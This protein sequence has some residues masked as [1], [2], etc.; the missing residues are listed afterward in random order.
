MLW[1]EP[2]QKAQTWSSWIGDIM[3]KTS[4]KD[5]KAPMSKPADEWETPS[6]EEK[7]AFLAFLGECFG[8]DLDIPADRAEELADL[9]V[10]CFM[11]VVAQMTSKRPVG[12]NE[13]KKVL[14]LGRLVIGQ[15]DKTEHDLESDPDNALVDLTDSPLPEKQ[16]FLRTMRSISSSGFFEKAEDDEAE[17]DHVIKIFAGLAAAGGRK[18]RSLDELATVITAAHELG[19][20]L[21]EAHQSAFDQLLQLPSMDGALSGKEG[22]AIVQQMTEGFAEVLRKQMEELDLDRMAGREDCKD[23]KSL[24]TMLG[25]VMNQMMKSAMGDMQKT[26]ES[27]IHAGLDAKLEGIQSQLGELCQSQERL[28]EIQDQLAQL[29]AASRRQEEFGDVP[30]MPTVDQTSASKKEYT[31]DR[32]RITAT[33]DPVL[34]ELFHQERRARGV[35]VSRMLDILLWQRYEKPKLS[36][37]IKVDEAPLSGPR[38]TTAGKGGLEKGGSRNE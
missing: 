36:F 7:L 3:K 16:R 9:M 10:T 35:T 29:T 4:K 12:L 34:F 19:R 6:K 2:P 32:E 14:S 26:F 31:V 18:P 23:P 22:E 1:M 15:V 21:F 11:P 28:E 20:P 27:T 5:S 13:I 17:L 24:G 8:T 25:S 38:E 33:V 30:P 37:E